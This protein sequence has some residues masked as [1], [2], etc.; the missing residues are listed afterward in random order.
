MSSTDTTLV[1]QSAVFVW[2]DRALFI[3]G[4]SETSL[5]SHHAIELS[6]ALDDL[7]IDVSAPG[8]P[9]L[10]GVGGA[11]VR[12]GAEHRLAIPG[13][14]VAVL[15][16]DPQSDVATSLHEWLGAEDLRVLS[17]DLIGEHRTRL[18][19]LL[20]TSKLGLREAKGTCSALLA[21]LVQESPRPAMDYRVRRA[22]ARI[23]EALEEPPTL[24]ALASELNV[25]SSRLRHMFREQVGLPLS[26]YVL[27]MRLRAALLRA[28]EG[29]SMAESA[30][31][32]GFS[33]SAH[34]TRTCRQMFGLPPTAFAP[35]DQVFVE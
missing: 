4:R 32:A 34:F 26:R 35:V 1:R 11:V 6:V 25:S 12:A 29:K 24:E 7:G 13:P 23:D 9:S 5:H 16:V 15:Y 10:V 18:R 31:A 28:L 8:A 22:I 14:K 27:W 17:K 33:D 30:Q 20:E 3:G 21:A 2:P 19:T